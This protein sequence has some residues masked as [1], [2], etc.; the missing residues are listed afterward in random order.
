MIQVGRH[1]IPESKK[2]PNSRNIGIRLSL[3]HPFM[4][5]FAGTD[6][7]KIEPILRMSAALGLAELIAKESRASTPGE[8][9][10]NFND[11][12]TK[13]ST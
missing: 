11:L 10:R 13:L 2:A 7:Q 5:Q 8:I 12:I 3:T 4:I 6:N 1:L 9:R